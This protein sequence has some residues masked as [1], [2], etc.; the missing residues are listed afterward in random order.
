MADW[1]RC[2]AESIRNE[3]RAIEEKYGIKLGQ[4]EIYCARCGKPWR[5]GGHVCQDVRFQRLNEGRKSEAKKKASLRELR[6][7]EMISKLKRMGAKKASTMLYV[8]ENG[9][10]IQDVSESNVR[11]WIK[12]KNIPVKYQEAVGAL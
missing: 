4:T 11:A 10:V 2:C 9:N 1:N 3:K 7:P 8:E 6:T 5:F 12:K